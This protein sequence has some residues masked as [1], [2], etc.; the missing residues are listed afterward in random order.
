MLCT[1]FSFKLCTYVSVVEG[2][3]YTMTESG[4]FGQQV[5]QSILIFF[6]S[7]IVDEGIITGW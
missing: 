1:D 5:M 3:L 7:K 6:K 4:W 2:S